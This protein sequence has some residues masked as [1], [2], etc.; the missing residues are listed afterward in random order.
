MEPTPPA[1][2]SKKPLDCQVILK[3]IFD[4]KVLVGSIFSCSALNMPSHSV[5]AFK[6]SAEK[7][8]GY[9]MGVL[10]Y[11]RIF[12]SLTAFKILLFFLIFE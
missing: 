4:S 3:D 8:T 6:V 9:L 11:A 1:L 7:S 10:L 12:F 2:D 5:L